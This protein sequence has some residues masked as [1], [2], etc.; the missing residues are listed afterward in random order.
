MNHRTQKGKTMKRIRTLVTIAA[1]LWLF[2]SGCT[3]PR[4]FNDTQK[5]TLR[6]AQ[7]IKVEVQEISAANSQTGDVS[8]Q[9]VEDII[10]EKV[11]AAGLKVAD[12]GQDSDA[13]MLVAFGFFKMQ[14]YGQL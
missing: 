9:E 14:F 12:P 10:K 5:A 3:G 7:V 8:K 11:R 1:A 2:A 13:S 6:Q 4:S